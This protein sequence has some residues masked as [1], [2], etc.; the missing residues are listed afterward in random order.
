[1]FHYDGFSKLILLF[2]RQKL[3]IVIRLLIICIDGAVA[4]WNDCMAAK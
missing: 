2:K 4:E 3:E 1:M